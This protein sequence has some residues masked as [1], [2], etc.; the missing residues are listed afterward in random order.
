MEG[1]EWKRETKK[2]H[3]KDKFQ[4]SAVGCNYQQTA[5]LRR[6]GEEHETYVGRELIKSSGVQ[7]NVRRFGRLEKACRATLTKDGRGSIDAEEAFSKAL[8]ASERE[9]EGVRRRHG[10][11]VVMEREA[12]EEDEE[13]ADER[14]EG[15]DKGAT[16]KEVGHQENRSEEGRQKT[17]KEEGVEDGPG[18]DSDEDRTEQHIQE[19]VAS[20]EGGLSDRHGEDERGGGERK[21]NEEEEPKMGKIDQ[22]KSDVGNDRGRGEKGSMWEGSK[23]EEG[24]ETSLKR[25]EEEKGGYEDEDL[26]DEIVEDEEEG[27]KVNIEQEG[28]R[29]WNESQGKPAK[30]AERGWLSE[31]MEG[32]GNPFEQRR[33]DTKRPAP[34]SLSPSQSSLYDAR[35]ASIQASKDQSTE[36]SRRVVRPEGIGDA[37]AGC[38]GQRFEKGGEVG[39]EEDGLDAGEAE[40]EEED[41]EDEEEEGGGEGRRRKRNGRRTRKR[42][43]RRGRRRRRRRATRKG[44]G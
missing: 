22:G 43:G 28:R 21:R 34:V 44:G 15:D 39:R 25:E 13:E 24:A 41:K 17:M 20:D 33:P 9:S 32:E 14:E 7:E 11:V 5:G 38:C 40:E 8:I 16:E 4:D 42:R 19:I 1:T 10:M 18:G 3:Q 2:S 29:L 27:L 35:T 30:S 6:S 31:A 37:E 12:E 36:N 23:G 26:E